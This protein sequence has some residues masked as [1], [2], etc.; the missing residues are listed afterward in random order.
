MPL[1][2]ERV[3]SS[4]KVLGGIAIIEDAHHDTSELRW[5]PAGE[6]MRE[7][8]LLLERARSLMP[9]LPLEEIDF[10]MIERMGKE[11]SGVGMDPNVIGR[12]MIHGEPEPPSPRIELIGVRDLTDASRGNACGVGLADFTTRKLFEKIDFRATAE[13]V[14]TST[15]Y[16]RAKLPLVLDDERDML[17]VALDHFRR[18]GNDRP[19]VL[20]IRDTLTLDELLASESALAA[21]AGR[22]D[23][24]LL[25]PLREYPFRDET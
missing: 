19:R 21:L 17:R 12:M 23:I 2:A 5:L 1:L 22:P 15:F 8:P 18:R 9:R 24:E 6:I 14:L 13:N 4:G 10:L 7:E 11:I 20:L 25:S 3:F 16:Q